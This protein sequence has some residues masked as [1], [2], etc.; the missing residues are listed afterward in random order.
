MM[1][2]NPIWNV[3]GLSQCKFISGRVAFYRTK[4]IKVGLYTQYGTFQFGQ[5]GTFWAEVDSIAY[6]IEV[7]LGDPG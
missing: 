6:A 2:K 1:L 3:V 4:V 5:F 7:K